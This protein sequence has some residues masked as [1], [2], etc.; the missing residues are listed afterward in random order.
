MGP[1]L[2]LNLQFCTF[3]V[4]AGGR[5]RKLSAEPED[6]TPSKA[7]KLEIAPDMK[8][9]ET[10]FKGQ[11]NEK[12]ESNN[13]KNKK[14]KDLPKKSKRVTEEK[15]E[16]DSRGLQGLLK[17][18][19]KKSKK[20]NEKKEDS[21]DDIELEAEAAGKEGT[22]PDEEETSMTEEWAKYHENHQ[23]CDE[24]AVEVLKSTP[25]NTKK[26]KSTKKT[27]SNKKEDVKSI[28]TDKVLQECVTDK[29]N[30][31]REKQK[32]ILKTEKEKLKLLEKVEAPKAIVE[33]EEKSKV[34]NPDKLKKMKSNPLLKFLT[35]AKPTPETKIP[36]VNSQTVTAGDN[37]TKNTEGKSAIDAMEETE[38]IHVISEIPGT[39]TTTSTPRRTSPRKK[40]TAGT[41]L[42]PDPFRAKQLAIA[43]LKVRITELNIKMEKAVE[44]KDFL[45]AHEA[46]Q[47]ISKL[48]DELKSL[49]NDEDTSYES[50]SLLSVPATPVCTTPKAVTSR[51]VSVVTTPS[52]AAGTASATKKLT[53]VRA[54]KQDEAKAKKEALEKERNEKKDKLAQE[55]LAKK[56]AL[57][58]EKAE[59]ERKKE[60]EKK[61]KE[62]E[63]L[64]K[65]RVKKHERELAEAEKLKA[66]QEKEEE[67]MKKKLEK[68]AEQKLKEE[69]KKAKEEDEKE[70]A[71]KK[72]ET[73]KSFFSKSAIKVDKKIESEAQPDSSEGRNLSTF[74]VKKNTKL[75]PL[76]RNDPD[77]AKKRID[78][79]EMPCGPDGLYLTLLKS[80][81]YS[82]GKQGRTWPYEVTS[83]EADEEV[84]ILENESDDES[85]LEDELNETNENIILQSGKD[86]LVIP[87]AKLLK[88]HENKRPAYWGTWTK[89]SKVITG[90][91]PFGRD[92]DRF[93]YD[94][95]SDDD[96]EEEEEGESLSDAEDDK[97]KEEDN[98]DYEV[99]NTFFVP[100]GYL[101]DEE[102]T[103]KDEDEVFDPEFAKEKQKR[104][105]KE[106]EK[107]HKKKT[108]VLKPKLWGVYYESE[109][110]D[111]EAAAV[112]LA[113]ILGSFE[114]FLVGNNNT[115]D[116]T[117]SKPG[118]T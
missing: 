70:K 116:T 115:V 105:E 108:Q 14:S 72:A 35:K 36:E 2:N 46:K 4:D 104:D 23:S 64:H 71:K 13:K 11:L 21:D 55:K 37:K 103:A 50:Q 19:F 102:E 49:H 34:Q 74:T 101:S 8:G 28:E 88:F 89:K 90:R 30:A 10:E 114:G 57:E 7:A 9:K 16:E 84:T 48:E 6:K 96:W 41:P 20:K 80:A 81:N 86:A 76:V 78:S 24:T 56:E 68:E 29:S 39:P 12:R 51:N 95:D 47:S 63:K 112:Q 110:L 109:V 66:K 85:D 69:E 43:K 3:L 60:I 53:P 59:K 75:A 1:F 99:D 79:L 26:L 77:L 65:E 17:I 18:P 27:V 45:K 73:F 31:E 52:S 94:Y 38:G 106:F 83:V 98:E 97:D 67:K 61:A 91:R 82:V 93:D 117:F 54:R 25:T 42:T 44:D 113:R 58:K 40:V 5:K 87:R 100:H 22:E 15:S 118:E 92:E 107:E 62:V 33:D 32:S 111:T